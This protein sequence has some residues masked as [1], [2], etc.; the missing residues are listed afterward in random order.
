MGEKKVTGFDFLWC[1]LYACAAFAI[2]LLSQFVEGKMGVDVSNYSASQNIIH[3]VITTVLWV[4]A[5]I[6]VIYIG[7]KTTNFDIWEHRKKLKRWQ[8]VALLVCFVVNIIAK[9]LDWNGFKVLIEW[10][11][12]EPILFIF[13]YIYYLAEGFLISLV[14]V[15][16]Q[17][18]F[19]KWFKNDK[20]PYG[21]IVL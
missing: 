5:G 15:Y 2:E 21:V 20:I 1:A 19:E 12:K 8:Y 13:Q 14:I 7:K 10:N 17:K 9:Y 4:I 3:W 16:G 11:S 6:V 18:A